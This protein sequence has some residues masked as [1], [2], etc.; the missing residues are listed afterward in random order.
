MLDFETLAFF[1]ICVTV[2]AS[3]QE[4]LVSTPCCKTVY[5]DSL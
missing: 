2:A 3:K 1:G 4:F 5:P